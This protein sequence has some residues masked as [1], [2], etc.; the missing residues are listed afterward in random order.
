[1]LG[2]IVF[3]KGTGIQGLIAD[4]EWSGGRRAVIKLDASLAFNVFS[5]L[6]LEL[7]SRAETKATPSPAPKEITKTED[8]NEQEKK[9]A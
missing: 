3:H 6:E 1:M 8:D 2:D 4:F 7:V 9:E 5:V